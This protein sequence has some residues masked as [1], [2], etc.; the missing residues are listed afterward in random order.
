ML[1]CN[2]R[3]PRSEAYFVARA[4]HTV[5]FPCSQASSKTFFAIHARAV[6]M[7]SISCSPFP[8]VTSDRAVLD[9][10]TFPCPGG[11]D[12]AGESGML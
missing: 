2:V 10:P 3:N 1:V 11:E 8:P 6:F 12:A 5:F 7:S 4:N 9:Y